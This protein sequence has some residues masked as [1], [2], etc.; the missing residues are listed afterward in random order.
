[1]YLVIFCWQYTH[2]GQKLLQLRRAILFHLDR[3]N[4]LFHHS[5]HA[6]SSLP[7]GCGGHSTYCTAATTKKEYIITGNIEFSA[8]GKIIIAFFGCN[9][10]YYYWDLGKF[11]NLWKAISL[12]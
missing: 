12:L 6:L 10:Y 1:M 7:A 8:Y 9:N 5:S 3:F 11:N 2:V 4:R